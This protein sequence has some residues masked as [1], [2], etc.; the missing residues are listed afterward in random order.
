MGISQKL[1]AGFVLIAVIVLLVG[2]FGWRGITNTSQSIQRI[3]HVRLPSVHSLLTLKETATAVKAAQRSLLNPGLGIE[4]VKRQYDNIERENAKYRRVWG[5]YQALPKSP[6]EQELWDR[7]VAAWDAWQA[8]NAK[9]L[10]L[11]RRLVET[12][13]LNPLRLR[14]TLERI[15]SY[16]YNLVG[17]VGNILQTE[18]EF[19]GG[20]D[21]EKSPLKEWMAGYQ[22]NNPEILAALGEV[23]KPHDH[24]YY[25]IGQI[26]EH[27]RKGDIDAASFTY[28]RDLMPSAQA[29]FNQFDRMVKQA[30]MAEEL[31]EQ[32]NR[33]AMVTCIETQRR[34]VALLDSL[35]AVNSEILNANTEGAVSEA[36]GAKWTA[37]AGI[38]LG[39]S[40]ALIIGL[41][42][43]RSIVRSLKRVIGGMTEACNQVATASAQVAASS[44]QLAEG[45]SVQASSIEETATALQ[46]M[47]DMTGRNAGSANHANSS[48]QETSTVVGE[49]KVSMAEL[50]AS[51]EEI[52]QASEETQKIVKT[53]DEISFQTNLLALNAAVEA[54]RAGEAG[55][56]FAVVAAEVRKLAMRAAEAARNTAALIE[57]TVKTVRAGSE[58]VSKATGEFERVTAGAGELGTLIGEIAAASVK[59]AQG[60]ELLNKAVGEMG[61]VT[62]CNA[63]GS[64]ESA[65][66]SDELNAQAEQMEEFVVELQKLIGGRR[67]N[68][69]ASSSKGMEI[70]L[71]EKPVM[72][73]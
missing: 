67:D 40:L 68:L 59:Q 5:V 29:I 20:D 41:W 42:I 72:A 31:Y 65:F 56:G 12:D 49:V 28:E 43:S 37:L 32:M 57:R 60:I 55:V 66:A 11:S 35:V 15:K 3:A 19:E 17:Q 50:R 24:F 69:G 30:E 10:D 47:A 61:K 26:K 71:E 23:V 51:M 73:G 13:V 53:I 52:I 2:F 46:E 8:D 25:T 62:Q 36:K 33:Q 45:A 27:I 70:L 48:M 54:A 39:F 4:G 64:E 14:E 34:A 1:I 9:F 7:F 63:A 58:T 21:P 44:R 38:A 18:I 22:T 6:K 16:H